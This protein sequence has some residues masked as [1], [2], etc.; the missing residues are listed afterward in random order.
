MRIGLLADTHVPYR[1]DSI[2]DPVLDTL[3][4]V[5]LILHA[6]DVDEP[7]A[8]DVLRELAPVYAVRGN[9]HLFDGSSGGASLPETV[10]LEATGFRIGM[11][12]GHRMG[13]ATWFWKFYLLFE[14]MHGQWSPPAYDRALARALVRRFPQADIIVFGHTH[15]FY[16]AYWGKTLLINPGAALRTAYFDAPHA[17]SLAHLILEPGHP[18]EVHRI[19][20]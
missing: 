13:L 10:E 6:G 15:R 4:G 11:A 16:Q 5:D 19:Q 3:R 20:T 7:W 14:N 1:A 2:P 8:L 17:P 12:H 9:Y 18:P